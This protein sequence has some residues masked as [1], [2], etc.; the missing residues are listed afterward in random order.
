MKKAQVTAFIII[1]LIVLISVILFIYFKSVL[2]TSPEPITDEIKPINLYIEECIQ[3]SAKSAITLIGA[4]GGFIKIPYNID[5]NQA[6]YINPDKI[7][8][9]KLPYWY[10]KGNRHSPSVFSVERD[11]SLYITESVKNCIDDFSD[12][13]PQFNITE[14][15]EMKISTFLNKNDV[16]IVM[17][18]PISIKYKGDSSS[19]KIERFSTVIDVRLR[20]LIEHSN[21]LLDQELTDFF[22]EYFTVNLMA[23][24]PDIPFTGME[25]TCSPLKW[26]IKSVEQELRDL[27]V[28]NVP[29]IRVANTNYP[30]FQRPISQYKALEKLTMQDI[31]DN[32]Y[33]KNPPPDKYEYLH[34]LWDAGLSDK[35][36]SIGFE[37]RNEFPIDI[38]SH[39]HQNGIM[40]SKP[41][42]GDDEY[43]SMIC[44]NA[45]HFVYD[46]NFPIIISLHDPLSYNGEGFTFSF[47]VPITIHNNEPFK[48]NYGYDLFTTTYLDEDFCNEREDKVSEIIVYGKE[49]GYSNLELKGVNLTMQC[50]RYSCPLGVTLADEGAY[51]MRVQLPKLCSNPFILAEK[52]GYL[53]D[54]AQITEERLNLNLK[55]L[56]QLDYEVI[57][58]R[59]NSFGSVIDPAEFLEED[60][61][62]SIKLSTENYHQYL[63]YP[64]TDNQLKIIEGSEEYSLDIVL[65]QNGEYVGG[66]IGT[67]NTDS[68][69]V[70][71]ADR[72]TFNVIKYVPTPFTKE[73]KINMVGYLLSD[74]YQSELRPELS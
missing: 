13:K 25:F 74:N 45:Y 21:K 5:Y 15:K 59:Y 7:G 30:D 51:R 19:T 14:L 46:V 71:I 56:K 35:T 38:I 62:V 1:G 58:R 27:L 32:K 33:P 20:T 29:R 64:A 65:T 47:A 55:K 8:I 10:Y 40:K 42:K 48:E 11:I 31:A 2:L 73:A 18:Y 4:Q 70:A 37:F 50:L 36:V 53:S 26:D 16:T 34:M 41:I 9:V 60:M 17:D 23:A 68:G 52:E 28:Y 43:L 12:F 57:M 24:N 72:V 44:M 54:R 39:P 67:W 63:D 22:L 6:K 61:E 66:Y 49:D 69:D 3:D